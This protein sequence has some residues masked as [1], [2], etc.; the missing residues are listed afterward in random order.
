M[1]IEHYD[2]DYVLAPELEENADY[3]YEMHTRTLRRFY[4]ANTLFSALV[5]VLSAG[6]LSIDQWVTTA[7]YAFG[8]IAVIT[9]MM[10]T[11]WFFISIWYG[12]F[13]KTGYESFQKDVNKYRKKD[14]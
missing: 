13:K 6:L 10:A 4:I 8:I 1:P 3:H 12:L 7:D 5:I 14:R 11:I 9:I 2:H